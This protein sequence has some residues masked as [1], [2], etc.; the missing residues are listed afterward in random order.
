M[1]PQRLFEFL[2]S[3]KPES[4]C[5]ASELTYFSST[6]DTVRVFEGRMDQVSF[7]HTEGLGIKVWLGDAW[8]YAYTESM[9][10]EAFQKA[11]TLAV[12]HAGIASPDPEDRPISAPHRGAA[13]NP[14]HSPIAL[15]PP[16]MLTQAL[17]LEAQTRA[18]HPAI[19]N[20]TDTTL[21]QC[22]EDFAILNTLG[23]SVC[24]SQFT[25]GA[26]VSALAKSGNQIIN[27]W[28]EGFA[29]HAGI[30]IQDMVDWL[31][32]EVALRLRPA[33]VVAGARTVIFHPVAARQI[34]KRFEPV[35]SGESVLHHTTL[36]E[37]KLDQLIASPRV[38]LVDDPQNGPVPRSVDGDGLPTSRLTLIDNGRLINFFHNDYTAR[39]LKATA[40]ARAVRGL[41]SPRG[42]SSSHLILE[43]GELSLREL[44]RE[45]GSGILIMDLAGASASPI[46]GDFS[47]SALGHVFE[48]GEI[49]GFAS[50]FTIAG[51]FLELLK[52]ITQ[53]GCD[54]E[55]EVPSLWGACGM[56]P[57]VVENINVATD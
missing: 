16:E 12:A 7:A 10:H 9:N 39:C 1:I 55:F 21:S 46:T 44:M 30:P 41:K 25:Q 8:G 37:G 56:P 53:V 32:R 36:L 13:S 20:V 42:I 29:T 31:A 43:P 27:P 23:H 47:Y 14:T 2:E 5:D 4:T 22:H 50:G 38:N 49:T 35:F 33:R 34:L 26:A 11:F 57:I 17:H 15:E 6:T 3:L 54:L 40:N 48:N 51:N 24:F 28:R 18:A 19:Y 52:N 45:T